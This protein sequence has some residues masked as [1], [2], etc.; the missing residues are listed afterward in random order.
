[1]IKETVKYTNFNNEEV[2]SD[3]YF[4]MSKMEILDLGVDNFAERLNR[5]AKERDARNVLEEV[6][7]IVHAAYGEKSEDGKRFVKSEEIL[8]KFKSSPA[9]DEFLFTLLTDVDKASAFINALFPEEVLD[10][11]KARVEEGVKKVEKQSI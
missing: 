8:S 5:I 3:I 4:N 10:K 11:M 7:Y 9:Y 1:M 2:E 6:K